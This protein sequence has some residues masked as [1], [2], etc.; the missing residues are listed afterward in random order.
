M[1]TDA[2]IKSTPAIQRMLAA[3]FEGFSYEYAYHFTGRGL[4]DGFYRDQDLNTFLNILKSFYQKLIEFIFSDGKKTLFDENPTY[5][6][7]EEGCKDFFYYDVSNN[8]ADSM[9]E[10]IFSLFNDYKN[11]VGAW[12]I[13]SLVGKFKLDNYENCKTDYITRQFQ[14]NDEDYREGIINTYGPRQAIHDGKLFRTEITLNMMLHQTQIYILELMIHLCHTVNRIE[15]AST[16]SG[17]PPSS[18]ENAASTTPTVQQQNP[19]SPSGHQDS[20]VVH[21]DESK[22]QATPSQ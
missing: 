21:K 10:I 3:H 15:K 20:G 19:V 18:Q 22:Q 5:S 8:A 7:A 17:E 6:L 2:T 13:S 11:T 16:P 12:D 4:S 14:K 1:L 9:A